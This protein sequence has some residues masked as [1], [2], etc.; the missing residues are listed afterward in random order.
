MNLTKENI[1]LENIGIYCYENGIKEYED[2]TKINVTAEQKQIEQA[3]LPA[4][5]EKTFQNDIPVSYTHLTLPTSDL[6]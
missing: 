3:Q 5:W 2:R 6:V 1:S 4:L